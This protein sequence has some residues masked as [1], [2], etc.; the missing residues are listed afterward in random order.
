MFIQLPLFGAFFIIV[1][2]RA[3]SVNGNAK[4]KAK[5]TI[6]TAGAIALPV[7]VDASTRRKPTI[8][9]VQEKE[10]SVSVK[11]IRK[12]PKRPAVLEALESTALFHLEGRVISKPPKKLAPKMRSIR[13]KMMLK[14]AFVDKL[15]SALA[16]K[17]PD[18]TSPSVT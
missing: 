5:P 3:K 11:A 8:G 7:E 12:I 15:F 2:K 18:M 9:A 1:G 10:T 4:A 17:S 6:P 14:T 16:P 13:Q